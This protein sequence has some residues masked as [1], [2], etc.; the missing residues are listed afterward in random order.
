MRVL[1]VYA[2]GSGDQSSI[3]FSKNVRPGLM[4]EITHIMGNMQTV[5]QGKYLGLPMVVSRTKQQ[6][7]GFVKTTIQQRMLKWKNRS[8][9]SAGK[10]IMLKSVALAMP[11]Y[12]MSY[13]KIP[14]RL[15]KEISSLMSNYWWG[16]TNGKNKIHWC[17]WRKLIPNKNM[18]GLGFK[19]LEAF[20]TALLGKQANK[21]ERI[22]NESSTSWDNHTS[23]VWKELWR[24]KV[25]HKQKIFLWKCLNNALPVRDIIHGRIKVGDPICNGCGE[26]RETIE[27]TFLNYVQAKLTWKLAPIQWEGMMEQHGCFRRWW[28]SITEAKHRPHDWQHIS[29]TVHILWQIWKE[30][31]EV[32]FN[33]KK[34]RPWRTIQKAMK[35]CIG[36]TRDKN[37]LWLGIGIC[38]TEADQGSKR[39]WA[40]R[41]TSS[42]SVLLDEAIALK[43]A[44][45]KATNM[46]HRAVQF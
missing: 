44:M 31:N 34:Y 1:H 9:S 28:I 27:H 2:L 14:S 40:L 20:N 32:E 25:K 11:T 22:Q 29:L 38:L 16:E 15:C 46:Q 45:C 37:Q 33:G 41:E 21:Q 35:E 10:E 18:G 24:L 17:S 7:F 30:R 39:G 36:I 43:L 8:L 13:F 4:N 6:I 23:K 26:E 12:T 3:L 19:D 42:G 5:S